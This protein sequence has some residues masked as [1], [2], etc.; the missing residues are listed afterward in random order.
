MSNIKIVDNGEYGEIICRFLQSNLHKVVKVEGNDLWEILSDILIGTKETRFGPRPT[1]ENA[2]VI[3]SVV[4]KATDMALPIPILIPWGGRKM[5]KN[6]SLDVAELSALRQLLHVDEMVKKFYAP[7]LIMRIRIEDI[8]ARWLYK[9]NEGIDDYS[10]SLQSLIR[11]IKGDSKILGVRESEVMNLDEYMTLA[12]EYSEL[13][14]KAIWAMEEFPDMDIMQIPEYVTLLEKGWK[15]DIPK[16]QRDYYLD[17]YKRLYPGK[18]K[19]E[20]YSMLA[21]YFAGS[22]VRYDLNGRCAPMTRVKDF[23]QIN[24]AHPVPGAP[25]SIFSNTL[26]YRTVPESMGR[27]HIAPWRAKGFLEIMDD[28]VTPKLIHPGAEHE[29]LRKN[30]TTFESEHE[31][32][33]QVRTDYAYMDSMVRYMP[34]I[35]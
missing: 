16:H 30:I 14:S 7:G 1:P 5:D 28:I 9:E 24:F 17:R 23:I 18:E 27:T 22:K 35:M 6:L 26:Y 29:A 3:R 11:L 32:S 4:K 2:V 33:V 19:E 34:V 20:Y 12:E 15:G 13:L 31:D 8:N 25:R 10:S 21:D